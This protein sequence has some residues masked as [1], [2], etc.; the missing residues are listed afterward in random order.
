MARF[1]PTTVLA[2]L[3]RRAGQILRFA[4]G[5][6]LILA[7]VLGVA[8]PILPGWALIAAGILVLAPKSRAAT[9]LRRLFARL[10]A[11]TRRR[12]TSGG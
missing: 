1:R 5:A 11:W 7:G 12:L 9:W 8:L 6:F 3:S 2:Y 4:A 10:K